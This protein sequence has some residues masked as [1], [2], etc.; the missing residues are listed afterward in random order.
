[1]IVPNGQL[2]EHSLV[3]LTL[4]DDIGTTVRVG[5]AYGSEVRRVGKAEW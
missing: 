1:M 5:V 3:N 4:S 2:L